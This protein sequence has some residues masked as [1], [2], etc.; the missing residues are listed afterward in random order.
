MERLESDIKT[1]R[2]AGSK[3]VCIMFHSGTEKEYTS[4]A[5]QERLFR[6]AIDMGADIVVG[7]HPHVIQG[8]EL[9]KDKVICY[10]L[11]NFCFGAN[12]NPKDKDTLIYQQTFKVKGDSI[13]YGEY[14]VIPCSISSE[15]DKN[16]YQPI[17]LEGAEYER[18]LNKIKKSSEKY[19]RT[20]FSEN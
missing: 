4:N 18:V 10:S 17:V 15:K 19:E 2:E 12:R 13:E 14:K 5:V 9:Y 3:L 1:E 20:L 11:G 6:Y 7:S 16:N 8:I